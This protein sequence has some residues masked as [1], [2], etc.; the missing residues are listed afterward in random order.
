MEELLPQAPTL[1]RLLPPALVGS[2]AH[3]GGAGLGR[4]VRNW[5]LLW[6]AAW[7]GD[8][9]TAKLCPVVNPDMQ[10]RPASSYGQTGLAEGQSARGGQGTGTEC[11][12][13]E[14][15]ER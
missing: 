11:P 3:E 6:Q 12:L 9:S 14:P 15:V 5:C 4:G 13:C 8:L 10:L 1:E 2:V 7:E